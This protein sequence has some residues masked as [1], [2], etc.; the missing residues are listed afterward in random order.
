VVLAAVRGTAASGGCFQ[1][2]GPRDARDFK[3]IVEYLAG[4]AFRL[5]L[6]SALG[7]GA[8]STNGRV[9][10]VDLS[11]GASTS[12]FGAMLHPKGLA[13]IVPMSPTPSPYDV[14][15]YDGVNS[16]VTTT[17]FAATYLA[18]TSNPNDPPTELSVLNHLQR[19]GCFAAN[20]LNAYDPSGNKTTFWQD[21]EQRD[22]AL[23]GV[24][25]ED[26]KVPVLFTRGIYDWVLPSLNV[27]NWYRRIRGFK[28]AILFQSGHY[29][30]Y[31]PTGRGTRSVDGMRV[32]R[33]WLDRWLR[34]LPTGV[35]DWPAVQAEDPIHRWRVV[36]SVEGMGK[37]LRYYL[38][39][40]SQLIGVEGDLGVPELVPSTASFQEAVGTTWST[41]PFAEATHLTGLVS[42]DLWLELDQTAGNIT[43][44]LEAVSPDPMVSPQLLSVGG[45]SARHRDDPANPTDVPVGVPTQ[46]H[47]R[48]TMIDAWVATGWRLR[49]TLRGVDTN[50]VPTPPGNVGTI[51]LPARGTLYTATVLQ[52]RD[53]PSLINLQVVRSPECL[54]VPTAYDAAGNVTAW[55]PADCVSSP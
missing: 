3:A 39:L 44:R 4:D 19:V 28:R 20:F 6:A 52:D 50:N 45:V 24:R 11:Y 54:Q 36:P 41:D 48:M 43:A 13:T 25:V 22:N 7:V 38:T 42:L 18:L 53:H 29:A 15:Y 17:V 31:E 47:V 2:I 32:V 10:S 21:R 40:G 14:A 49:L 37:R 30:F 34:D 8:V 51:T 23:F 5:A 55:S 35:E 27:E 1:M 26:I 46:F 12:T 9:A 16:L 33:A